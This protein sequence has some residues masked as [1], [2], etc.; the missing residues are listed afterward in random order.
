MTW[1]SIAFLP[2]FLYAISNIIDRVLLEKKIRHPFVSF[3]MLCS[4]GF[5]LSPGIL[6][7]EKNNIPSWPIVLQS[8]GVGLVLGGA[9]VIY[10]IVLQR[11]E[12]S[13]VINLIYLFPLIT[14]VGKH[15]VLHTFFFPLQIMGIFLT[16]LGAVLTIM[17][18]QEK[19][20]MAISVLLWLF[21]FILFNGGVRTYEKFLLSD[22]DATTL[23][24]IEFMGI[25]CLGIILFLWHHAARQEWD[26]LWE[27]QKKV[28][29]TTITSESIGYTTDILFII[30][31]T[32][33]PITLV[34]IISTSQVVFV[35]LFSLLL[36]T[37][38]PILYKR[39]LIEK[40]SGC[41]GYLLSVL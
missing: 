10:C 15:Y 19:T 21:L 5:I 38:F 20:T 41:R 25:L 30:A 3:W 28:V 32:F 18:Q 37:L 14:F 34:S 31:A 23:V 4:I 22:M 29:G 27:K 7:M 6:G 11:E 36:S 17:K 26:N 35:L 9:F 8:F 12:A 33:A 24:A 2:P 1:I 16:I 39:P 13:R 40:P